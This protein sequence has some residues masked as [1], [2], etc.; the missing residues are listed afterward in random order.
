MFRCFLWM[1]CWSAVKKANPCCLV[2][3]STSAGS[4]SLNHG[5]IQSKCEM[6]MVWIVKEIVNTRRELTFFSG[7]QNSANGRV[8][9]TKW[10]TSTSVAEYTSDLR[11]KESIL[12][13]TVQSQVNFR[14][15]KL[16]RFVQ[17]LMEGA[18]FFNFAILFLTIGNFPQT[19]IRY[20][21]TVADRVS[22]KVA[23]P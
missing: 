20:P 13:S 2:L 10:K 21:A 5:I 3:S 1:L 6:E 12:C 7:I 16:S 17:Q 14:W 15:K 8:F 19:G 11:V 18:F 22:G 4:G 23:L 9:F